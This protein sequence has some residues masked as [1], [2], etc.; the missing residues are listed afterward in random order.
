M[1]ALVRGEQCEVKCVLMWTGRCTQ[2]R[3]SAG[4]RVIEVAPIIGGKAHRELIRVVEIANGHVV[5]MPA[6]YVRVMNSG[7]PTWEES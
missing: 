2:Y 7:G 4:Y 6:S 3:W 5:N 1:N